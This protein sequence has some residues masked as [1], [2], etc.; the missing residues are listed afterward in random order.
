MTLELLVEVHRKYEGGG[1]GPQP[2]KFTFDWS[3]LQAIEENQGAF[4]DVYK[5]VILFKKPVYLVD[6]EDLEYYIE[7]VESRDEILDSEV[8]F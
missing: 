2:V 3:N 4:K 1:E 6:M 8:F 5:S 7:V